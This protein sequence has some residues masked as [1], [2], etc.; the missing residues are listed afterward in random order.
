MIGYI[1]KYTPIDIIESFGEK[2]I[3]ITPNVESF[4]KANTLTHDN[5]CSYAKAI[6]EECYRSNIDKLILT[7]CCD[8]IR[9]LYDIL[10]RENT[11]KFLYLMDFPR[12]LNTTSFYLYEKEIYELIHSLEAFLNKNFNSHALYLN[13]CSKQNNFNKN[14]ELDKEAT[15]SILIMGAPLSPS[16]SFTLNFSKYKVI[17]KTCTNYSLD[18]SKF[19]VPSQNYLIKEYAKIVLSQFPCMRMCDISKRQDFLYKNNLNIKGII[20]NT[21][22][23]CD[24]Y[25]F[26]YASLKS[27]SS[28]PILKLETDFLNQNNGQISTR[29][30]AFFESL[31]KAS[32]N[33]KPSK[34]EMNSIYFAGL[35]SGSTS[36]NVVIIDDKNNILSFSVVKTG[37]KSI[38]GAYKALEESLNKCN[39][40]KDDLK[41]VVS[42]GYGRETVDF[43][44]E[45]ITEI[46]C[47]AK[48][49][50]YINN[51]VKT[52][53]DIGGQDS[54]VINLDSKGNVKEFAM[55]DKCAAGTGRFLENMCKVLD[56]PVD[57]MGDECL[58]WK[59]NLT[60]TSMCTVFAESEVVSLIAENKETPDI[61]HGICKSVSTRVLSLLNRVIKDPTELKSNEIMMTGGVA[62]NIGVV[63]TLEKLLNNNLYI[64][65]EPQIIGAL[66]AAIY[67]KDKYFNR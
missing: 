23:F 65:K 43:S 3:K 21:L 20:Y 9:R 63:K 67:A 36:T 17:D 42:T 57:A 22:K 52:I 49:A 56:M 48:G 30:E 66:G 8:S 51:N 64:P 27:S 33:S 15:D 55:N 34:N 28:I 39:L 47:H 53:I 12:K 7:N 54:K 1:C 38:N 44:D 32:I 11:F 35:D 16:L 24:Y 18:Y 45:T 31:E 6:L 2:T 40:K 14:N 37:A 29:I 41:Y 50:Y 59:E 4:F 60:I 5:M 61:V 58:K 46:T 13:I 62:K 26:E 25:S 10:K 19:R